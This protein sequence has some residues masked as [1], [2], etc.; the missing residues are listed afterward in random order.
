M[1]VYIFRAQSHTLGKTISGE[2]QAEDEWTVRERLLQ[3]N[4]EPLRVYKKSILN[5][6][7]D[8]LIPYRSKVKPEDLLFFC[9]QF[10][11]LISAGISVGRG[12]EICKKQCNSIILRRYLKEVS[13][14]ISD[15]K[16]L[17]IAFQDT[18]AFPEILISMI[19]CGEASGKLDDVLKEMSGYFTRQ[20]EVT[21]KIKKAL[22]YPL[23]VM[24][25]VMVAIIFLM[26]I[27]IPNFRILLSEM[28]ADLPIPTQ[29]VFAVSTYC[30]NEWP[31][32]LG[33]ISAIMVIGCIFLRSKKGQKVKDVV[34][35]KLPIWG[36]MKRKSLTAT[37][38]STMEMLVEAGVP[39]LEA[40]EITRKVT[41]NTV[42]EKEIECTLGH[43]KAGQG[44]GEALKKSKIYP[45][46][47]LNMIEVGEETGAMGEILHMVSEY[48]KEEVDSMVDRI[49]IWIE[50]LLIIVMAAIVGGLMLAV[51]L[52]TFSAIDQIM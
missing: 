44:L 19:T 36:A 9:K 41:P 3:K 48:F 51:I 26:V 24:V 6:Q 39:I 43:M 2:M 45:A 49:T 40:L 52:P 11:L 35:L 15:G 27:V 28:G 1:A 8:E 29:M 31:R 38:A 25:T 13:K 21:N 30:I 7:L 22:M 33:A 50:P 4:L 47:A 14:S 20:I 5:T 10:A 17:S 23:V 32:L 16:A 34:V 42:V 18:Q 37:F 12:L 46:I